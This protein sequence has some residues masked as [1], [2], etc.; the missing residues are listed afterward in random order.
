VAWRGEDWEPL[1]AYLIT[2]GG[3][4]DDWAE[5]RKFVLFYLIFAFE[6]QNHSAPGLV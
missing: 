1:G 4:S 5:G 6:I 3:G 2:L